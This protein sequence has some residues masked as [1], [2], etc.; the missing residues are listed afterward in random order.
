MKWRFREDVVIKGQEMK[1]CKFSN[2]VQTLNQRGVGPSWPFGL[3]RR[4]SKPLDLARADVT[5]L[6]VDGIIWWFQRSI[7]TSENQE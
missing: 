1:T 5:E 7:K 3:L 2:L 6:T 4:Y